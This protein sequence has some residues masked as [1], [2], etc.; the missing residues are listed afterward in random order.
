MTDRKMLVLVVGQLVAVATLAAILVVQVL[1]RS[2]VSDEITKLRNEQLSAR[3]EYKVLSVPSDAP[4]RTGADALKQTMIQPSDKDLT[5]LGSDGWEVVGTYV[6]METAY[7]NF[8]DE[9]YVTG[10]QPNI[11]PQ[12]VVVILRRRVG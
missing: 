8:G 9:K 7:P 3:Y 6:E 5:K 11:R 2:T 4:A 10:L 1:T 12:R